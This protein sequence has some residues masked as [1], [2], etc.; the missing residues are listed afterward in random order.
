MDTQLQLPVR[1]SDST[2]LKA[3]GLEGILD[4]VVEGVPL[5][6][7]AAMLGV[8]PASIVNWLNQ[9]DRK[10]EYR[11]AQRRS[12][13][14]LSDRAGAVLEDLAETGKAGE[15]TGPMVGLAKLQV[16]QLMRRAAI[17]N[18]KYRE[19]A[20]EDDAPAPKAPV[21]MPRFYI[22]IAPGLT[23]TVA[24]EHPAIEHKP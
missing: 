14:L 19:K 10:A 23:A 16:D 18:A 22:T 24:T 5:S 3:F 21:E 1:V 2:V 12:A 6:K 17:H 4:L 8:R 7:M 11:E 9:H 20:P 15:L 13:E